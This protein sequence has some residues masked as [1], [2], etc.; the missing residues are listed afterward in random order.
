MIGVVKKYHT[1]TRLARICNATAK[2]DQSRCEA[3]TS[4]TMPKDIPGTIRSIAPSLAQPR[5]RMRPH[6][7]SPQTAAKSKGRNGPPISHAPNHRQPLK[8]ERISGAVSITIP[9]AQRLAALSRKMVAMVVTP[10][11]GRINE[12]RL[13]TRL[14]KSWTLVSPALSSSARPDGSETRPHTAAAAFNV[15]AH[16]PFSPYHPVSG[17][18]QKHS[19]PEAA[20]GVGGAG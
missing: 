19:R 10:G 4:A 17:Y 3:V 7:I 6:P 5:I 9:M 20:A 1:T 8:F 2:N 14:S 11:G 15:I 16:F 18:R 13:A 12:R